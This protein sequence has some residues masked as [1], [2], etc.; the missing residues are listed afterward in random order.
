MGEGEWAVVRGRKAG[1]HTVTYGKQSAGWR[2]G[3]TFLVRN[4]PDDCRKEELWR[5]LGE[6]GK[7]EDLFLP[8]KRD[9]L[10]FRFGFVRLSNGG[11][12]EEMLVRLNRIWI[13]TYV[14]RAFIPK[15]ERGAGRVVRET[16][17]NLVGGGGSPRRIRLDIN[18]GGWRSKDVSFADILKRKQDGKG[19]QEGEEDG[20]EGGFVFLS[21]EDDKKWLEGAVTGH[22]KDSFSWEKSGEE[23]QSE[24]SGS[25]KITSMGN[26]LLLI[27]TENESETESI[28][29]GF[30]EWTTFWLDWWHPWRCS[31]FNQRREPWTK[32]TGIPLHAWS[33]S[34]FKEACNRFGLM[35]E[36]AEATKLRQRL[37]VAVVKVRTGLESIDRLLDCKI[38]G[39]WYKIRIEEISQA[40]M[41]FLE[42][43]GE[44]VESWSDSEAIFDPNNETP[45]DASVEAAW[46]RSEM[47]ESDDDTSEIGKEISEGNK[48][49]EESACAASMHAL[50]AAEGLGEQKTMMGDEVDP[51]NEEA[52]ALISRLALAEATSEIGGKDASSEEDA[53]NLGADNGPPISNGPGA[54][55][56]AQKSINTME[57]GPG[58]DI[59][60]SEAVVETPQA[61]SGPERLVIENVTKAQQSFFGN[62]GAGAKQRGKNKVGQRR[63]KKEAREKEVRNW[64]PFI[65]DIDTSGGNAAKLGKG[66]F[67]SLGKESAKGVESVGEA[68]G[69]MLG[70]LG[71]AEAGASSREVGGERGDGRLEEKETK[72]EVFSDE[73]G[74]E[75]WSRDG[76][77]WYSENAIGRSGGILSF[78]DE[79]RFEAR[80]MWGV[81]GAIVVSGIWKP[82]NEEVCII[83]VY[84]PC[85][86]EEKAML[87]ENILG[88][89]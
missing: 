35:V 71:S 43:M 17:E 76:V 10:G 36:L 38:D 45:D 8:K 69:K 34:F 28:L 50:E 53:V 32:W 9:K 59:L 12:T 23:L 11:S 72:L 44:V 67:A 87:W 63:W 51:S 78:W 15:H 80:N 55:N 86:R 40:E 49:D 13:G 83:N 79:S 19:V 29:N 58:L 39:V 56:E 37:D 75:L 4:F 22:L 68:F 77:G 16:R 20:E 66:D 74:R 54:G 27:Q 65:Q 73:V 89:L 2:L 7:V 61:V 1:K 18:S 48:G 30:E 6:A 33:E 47:A 60:N 57:G 88:V 41:E 3:T 84:A 21:A 24:C 42:E 25:L 70:L 62:K 46:A 64:K 52:A 26:N 31:D 82:V 5:R 14:I 85:G 81:G